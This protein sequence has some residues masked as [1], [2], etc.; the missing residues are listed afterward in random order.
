LNSKS[1]QIVKPRDVI[2]LGKSF[3]ILNNENNDDSVGEDEVQK[4]FKAYEVVEKI[5]KEEVYKAKRE[6]SKLKCWLN[7]GP[8]RFVESIDPGR[9]LILEKTNV[10]MNITGKPKQP[11]SFEEA[12]DYPNLDES[13]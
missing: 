3:G 11:D 10:S 13:A 6:A 5:D 1:E 12:H 8:E 9:E 7:P 2:W 4:D